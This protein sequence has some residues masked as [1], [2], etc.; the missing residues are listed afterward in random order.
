MRDVNANPGTR[1][2]Q[3]VVS[4]EVIARPRD[5]TLTKDRERSLPHRPASGSVRGAVDL[6]ALEDFHQCRPPLAHLLHSGCE[7]AKRV[8]GATPNTPADTTLAV[9]DLLQLVDRLDEVAVAVV[10]GAKL[11]D[12][13]R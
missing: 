4:T 8:A 3:S 11:R 5:C 2:K 9:D 7:A 12:V 10:A 1:A 6:A 13:E